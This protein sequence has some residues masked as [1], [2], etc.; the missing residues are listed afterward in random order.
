MTDPDATPRARLRR[1]PRR[2]PAP[3]PRRLA[4]AVVWA[5]IG[6]AVFVGLLVAAASVLGGRPLALPVW[7]VAEAETRL[8]RALNNR[9]TVS[10]GGAEVLFALDRLPELRLEELRLARTGGGMILL[11]EARARFDG[12]ALLRGRV[13]PV[14][15]RVSGAQIALRRNPDGRIDFDLGDGATEAPASLA[16]LLDRIDSFFALPALAMLDRVEADALTLT[17]DDRRAGRVWTVGDG[18]VSLIR[19]PEESVLDLAFGLMGGA[20]GPATAQMTFGIGHDGQGARLSARVDG[21]AAADLAAQAPVLG[22]LGVLDA[23]IAGDL[24]AHLATDGSVGALDG[25]LTVGAGALRPVEGARPVPLTG[26]EIVFGWDPARARIT[27]SRLSVDSPAL[28]LSAVAHADLTGMDDGV[29]DVFQAQIRFDDVLVNPEGIF[30][31]PVRFGQGALDLRL[32]LDPFS[33]DLGQ[34]SL[35]ED[36][37]HLLARGGVSAGR[38]GWTVA[39]DLELDAIRHDRLLALWPVGLVPNTR[40]WLVTNVQQ[41]LLFGVKAGVRLR[42]GQDPRLSLGYEFADADVRFMPT[43]PPIQG[44]RGYASIEGQTYITVVEDGHV[45]PPLGGEIRVARSVF[46]VPD[47]SKI[48]A[49]AEITLSTDSSL[50]AALSLLDQ[51]PF[52]F[53]GKAGMSPDLGTGRARLMT[54]LRLPLVRQILLPDVGFSVTGT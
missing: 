30:A 44:G 7:V 20:A 38:D 39:L 17:L 46:R 5:G 36:G 21:V 37:R 4:R 24:R 51:P 16:G 49:D 11:P 31:E 34:L 52:G 9:A 19:R 25:S 42:P 27:A 6:F 12:A 26:A 10:L 3:W 22:W 13:E 28:R 33:V 18:R 40:T 23:P 41:G 8:N 15:V 54:E 2:A 35:V 43:L 14:A 45:T 1:R 47:I 53:L 29:P 50:T 32:R 48:P